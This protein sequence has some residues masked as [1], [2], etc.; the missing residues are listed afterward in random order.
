MFSPD[1]VRKAITEL[2]RIEKSYHFATIV[3]TV[4][5]LGDTSIRD[6]AERKAQAVGVSGL[7]LLIA[8]REHK[9]ESVVSPR[10]RA[11][12]PPPAR[13][14]LSAALLDSFKKNEFDNGLAHAVAVVEKTL[15]KAKSDHTLPLEGSLSDSG[16]SL[17][18]RNQ[19]R[20]T[21]AGAR[22]IIEGA[23]AKASAMGWKMNIAVV[24]DGGHLVS[25][26]RMDGARPASVYTSITKATTA[27][28]YREET[29]PKPKG[30]SSPDV[31]LNLSLQNA[32]AASGGKVTTLLGG[33]PVVVDG[34][35]IGGVGVGGG[36]GEQDA[37]VAKAGL[38]K[39]MEAVRPVDESRSGP[40]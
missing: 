13:S 32:A 25:F 6:E 2:E 29:G 20:L 35:V 31:L 26:S 39:F 3:E 23:E 8:K 28:T 15:A 7:Y 22:R 4:D 27:A 21:Q 37:E 5:K 36:S 10:Y 34:Q 11:A 19:V 12:F 33:I 30:T 17:V 24:D 1:A 14:D 38:A 18:V 16:S 9:F 40:R